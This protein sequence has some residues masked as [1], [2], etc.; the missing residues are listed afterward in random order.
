MRNR[1]ALAKRRIGRSRAA[2]QSNPCTGLADPASEGYACWA[3]AVV[4]GGYLGGR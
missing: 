3:V 4:Q 1:E 2:A